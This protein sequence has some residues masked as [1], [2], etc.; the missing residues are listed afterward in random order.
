[1]MSALAMPQRPLVRVMPLPELQRAYGAIVPAR[2][3]EPLAS[4]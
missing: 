4:Q 2:H 1:M 3:F